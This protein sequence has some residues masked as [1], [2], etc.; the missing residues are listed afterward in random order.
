MADKSAK[1][2]QNVD[3]KFYVD[4]QC[5][6]CDACVMEAPRFFE[7]NDDEGHAFVKLQPSNDAELEECMS[8]LEACPVEA[9]GE[10]G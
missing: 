3:G 9:I 10:D 7:M 5:I 8:A 1:F 4:D 2:D 6:A